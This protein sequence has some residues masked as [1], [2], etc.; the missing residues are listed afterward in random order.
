MEADGL[1]RVRSVVVVPIEQGAWGFRSQPQR[2]HPHHAGNVHLAGARH[3]AVAHHAHDG[4]RH[5]AEVLLH[6]RPTL[7][8]AHLKVVLP[9]PVLDHHPQPRHL[10]QRFGGNAL[11]GDVRAD[12]LDL[13]Q[14]LRIRAGKLGDAAEHF[15]EVQGLHADAAH[16]EQLLAIADGLERRGTRADGPDA[17]P[18]QALR[19]A[20]HAGEPGEI[21]LELVRLQAFGVQRGKGVRNAVLLQVVADAHLAAEAVAAVGDEHPLRIVRKGVNQHRDVQVGQPQ[22]VSHGAFLAEIR[23][24]DDDAVDAVAVLAKQ[25]GDNLRMRAILHRAVLGLVRRRAD[26]FVPGG[27]QGRDHLLAPAARQ[28]V[29]EETAIADDDSECHGHK[30]TPLFFGARIKL[31]RV[32]GANN[33][34][35]AAPPDVGVQFAQRAGRQ[36]RAQGGKAVAED[37][38]SIE[39]HQDPGEEPDGDRSFACHVGYQNRML[40]TTR[41]TATTTAQK[42]GFWN[43]DRPSSLG[44]S[45]QP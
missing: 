15:G 35:N 14:H 6:G 8:R 3:Q 37:Y 22:R 36:R 9:H 10:A 45:V 11:R 40:T 4:T 5:H 39:G 29:G 31:D 16:F 44:S 23:Q 41:T 18:P 17:Q 2:M 43:K 38:D 26:H 34:H 30:R 20:A 19:H 24:G 33:Q 32:Y 27:R 28:M 1:V 12:G 42:A 13:R 25:V 7:D 21:V